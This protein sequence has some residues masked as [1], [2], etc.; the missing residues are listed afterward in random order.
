MTGLDIRVAAPGDLAALWVLAEEMRGECAVR[1]PPVDADAL[2]RH[3]DLAAACPDR[4]CVLIGW[5]GGAAVGVVAGALGEY[6]FSSERRA[7]CEF[8]FVRPFA[9]G[10]IAARRLLR[11]F[12]GW[13]RAGGARSVLFGLSAGIAPDRT[14]RFLEAEG[15]R[16]LGPTYRKEID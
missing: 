5:R 9:R 1:F 6:P 15:F 4:V 3:L 10:G 13:A 12:A 11:A 7:C 14:G 16:P 8:L 2:A